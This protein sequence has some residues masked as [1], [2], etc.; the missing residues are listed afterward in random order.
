MR[1]GVDSAWCVVEKRS[2]RRP[3]VRSMVRLRLPCCCEGIQVVLVTVWEGLVVRVGV[4]VGVGA[5]VVLRSGRHG[6]GLRLTA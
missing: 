5:P 4:G 2:G 6:D 1:S 3:G